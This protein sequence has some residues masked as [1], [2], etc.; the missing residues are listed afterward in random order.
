MIPDKWL[1]VEFKLYVS[2]WSALTRETSWCECKAVNESALARLDRSVPHNKR[3]S[4]SSHDKSRW[5]NSLTRLWWY[6]SLLKPSQP[7]SECWVVEVWG[8]SYSISL[9]AIIPWIDWSD[10]DMVASSTAKPWKPLL[11]HSSYPPTR[12]FGIQFALVFA[13]SSVLAKLG[14]ERSSG[15][16][17]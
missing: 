4:S 9:I 5:L 3:L 14:P 6:K 15:C 8:L 12:S 13:I 16:S 17:S 7:E 10:S 1:Q 11:K 2:T